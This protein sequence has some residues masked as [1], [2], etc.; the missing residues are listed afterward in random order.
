[1]QRLNLPSY[2]FRIKKGETRHQIF[3]DY[4]KKYVALT[5]E[6]WVRQNYIRFLVEEKRF[7]SALIAVEMGLKLNGMQ[8]RSDVVVYSS[9]GTPRLIVECKAPEVKV[10]QETFDQIARYNMVLKV[11]YLVVTNGLQHYCC[12]LDYDQE[13]YYFLR[14]VPH[15][16]EL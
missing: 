16:E 6:E 12:K 14:E 8:R 13:Q 9:L 11:D 3:D 5:P 2:Q 4:R 7:P 1:M 10:T 15:F